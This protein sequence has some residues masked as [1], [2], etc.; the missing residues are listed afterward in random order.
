[1]NHTENNTDDPDQLRA[2]TVYCASSPKIASHYFDVAHDLGSELARAGLTV[3][4]GGGRSGLMAAVI[5][6]ALDKGGKA[7][8]VLPE[9]MIKRGWHHLKLSSTIVTRSMHER[10]ATMAS[11]SRAAIALPGGIGTFEELMEIITWRQL[12]LYAGNVVILNVDGYYDPL[13]EM[14][15]RAI[16]LHFMNPDHRTLYS[17]TESV[18][19]AVE[20]ALRPI[21]PVEFSQ[22]I[23]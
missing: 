11:L 20:L 22:K 12:G 2:V 5:D 18:E 19:E 10:K 21:K 14:L 3:V 1:M 4:C 13:L 16:D 17:V 15:D 7:V 8:G 6:G 9:F 23:V